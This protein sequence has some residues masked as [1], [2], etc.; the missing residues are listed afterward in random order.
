V[1]QEERKGRFVSL[2]TKLAVAT[3]LVLTAMSFALFS[4][5]TQ[6][7]RR[8]L[9]EAKAVAGEMVSDLF[10][11][12][13]AAP[14][15]FADNDAVAVELD[16]L[17]GNKSIAYAAVYAVKEGRTVGEWNPSGREVYHFGQAAQHSGL[18]ERQDGIEI[19]K[20]IRDTHGQ[21]VGFAFLNFSLTDENVAY[22]VSRRRL[23]WWVLFATAGTA[24][25]LILL[26]RKLIVTPLARVT[27]AARRLEQGDLRARARVSAHDEVGTLAVVFNT[28][29]DAIV[30][31]QEKLM[32]AQ[33]NVQ[34]LFDN[35]L[36]AVFTVGPDG[37]I[38]DEVS[39]F[40]KQIFGDVPIAG[41]QVTEFLRLDVMAPGEAVSRMKF[42]LTQIFGSDD[43]QWDLCQPDRIR[44]LRY[45]RATG[46]GAREER[47]LELDYAPIYEGGLVVK[48]MFLVKDVTEM[49]RLQAEIVRR[50]QQS[51]EN[52]ARIRQIA[53][54]EPR[55]FHTFVAEAYALL[56][57]CEGA[58][59]DLD[60]PGRR[61]AAVGSLFRAMHTLK[62]N[63]RIFKLTAVEDIAH[64]TEDYVQELRDGPADVG[65]GAATALAMSARMGEVR[66]L[67]GE[68]EKLGRQVLGGEQDVP[69]E[70]ALAFLQ[71]HDEV[72]EVDGRRA[73]WQ[74]ELARL[75]AEGE[76]AV[77]CLAGRAGKLRIEAQ[78]HGFVTLVSALDDLLG[79]LGPGI[80]PAQTTS[81]LHKVDQVLQQTRALAEE[82]ASVE[83]WPY[84]REE[85]RTLLGGLAGRV[86][87]QGRASRDDEGDEASYVDL[88]AAAARSFGLPT[89]AEVATICR[90]AMEGGSMSARA[91][92]DTLE[93]WLADA[94]NLVEMRARPELDLD[95]LGRFHDDAGELIDR[96]GHATADQV[97]GLAIAAVACA[98]RYRFRLAETSL[99]ALAQTRPREGREVADALRRQVES[100][101]SIRREV[102]HNEAAEH[103]LLSWPR[104]AS[105]GEQ[106]V[107]AWLTAAGR[108][109]LTLLVSQ[110]CELS[111]S[112][113]VLLVEDVCRFNVVCPAHRGTKTGNPAQRV[114]EERL[115]VLDKSLRALRQ[116]TLHA[117]GDLGTIVPV[118]AEL[119]K[120]VAHLTVA[121]LGDVL[122]PVARAAHELA[123]DR[124]KDLEEV[125]LD[126]LDLFLD[127]NVMQRLRDAVV[128]A[129]RNAIDH[130]L[131]M[132]EARSAA[133]KLRRGRIGIS[134]SEKCGWVELTI[135][136]DGR[137]ID[138]ARVKEI[139]QGRGLVSAEQ[140]ATMPEQE[141]YELLFRPSFSTSR[142]VSSVS[143]R[144]V[145]M[146]A[147]RAIA[148]ELGGEAT[149][150][151]TSGLGTRLTIR[152]PL[153]APVARVAPVLR[154]TAESR[155]RLA[156]N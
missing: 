20:D 57:Q 22:Q 35:M 132:P 124:G 47:A 91:A 59:A 15:V 6:R 87:R 143:G 108:A 46:D 118:L 60:D 127:G 103:W 98:R 115:G 92:L 100:Y 138:M 1:A 131:E 129:V 86:A 80:S 90:G 38:N 32:R 26:A 149:I 9:I 125:D 65:A 41:Q 31:R 82:I 148:R 123:R 12:S 48:I 97:S 156:P 34:D 40:A 53:T 135:A 61:L 39:A 63:A 147:I 2:G 77:R 122:A 54:M 144:G 107:E 139:A 11:A 89:L 70:A 62:G 37:R 109:G 64:A 81:C 121:S 113:R 49:H 142:A 141:I 114:P 14:L 68:F 99:A 67:L 7:E 128:H 146:D 24:L 27:E 52:L 153:P 42:F 152:F 73:E 117:R 36:Q 126:S 136:D 21:V 79:R 150:A 106:A 5:L 30:D 56:D 69:G 151:S 155:I 8:R 16:K 133:G 154:R 84:F 71:G 58:V 55:I 111:A 112:A 4:Q 93:G 88:F 50:D 44:E 74:G 13:C 23:I 10:A 25:V 28:M 140:A 145:G 19:L 3:V 51:Q 78:G 75:D 85:A 110:A 76:E 101:E 29:G 105:E 104:A 18:V 17:R 72:D 102:R 116:A 130:G 120:A 95:I 66:Q 43:L 119:E 33:K 134:A 45:L 137:G 94:H 96:L 83:M